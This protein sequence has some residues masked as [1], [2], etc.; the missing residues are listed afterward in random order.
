MSSPNL[1]CSKCQ[2]TME[3]GFILDKEGQSAGGISYWVAGTPPD[4]SWWGLNIKGREKLMVITFR[5]TR[6][7][8]LESYTVSPEE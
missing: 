4:K 6:C 2:S 8:Y 7:G 1:K 3:E 5:C